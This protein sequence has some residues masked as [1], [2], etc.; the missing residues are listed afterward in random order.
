MCAGVCERDPCMHAQHTQHAREN[1]PFENS[2]RALNLRKPPPCCETRYHYHKH[3]MHLALLYF[4]SIQMPPADFVPRPQ[5]PMTPRVLKLRSAGAEAQDAAG[6]FNEWCSYRVEG[7]DC[8]AA[9][10]V[11][12]LFI[13]L[14][15][16]QLLAIWKNYH[17]L[18]TFSAS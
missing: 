4:E 12:G 15:L 10:R 1:A 13:C 17:A 7:P 9:K 8:H 5:S 3:I 6:D 16:S 11:F 18:A 2:R 14:S